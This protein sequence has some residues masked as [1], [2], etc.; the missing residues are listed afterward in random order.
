M[1]TPD[2]TEALITHARA[3]SLEAIPADAL[4]VA[5]QC[6]MDFT[7]CALGGANDPLV[8]ILV[9]ELAAP[10]AARAIARRHRARA[11]CTRTA[12]ADGQARNP[13]ITGYKFSTSP[14]R[15]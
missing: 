8:D 15:Y 10:Q 4:Q 6:L 13:M 9:A 5:R 1:S 7:A 11:Q 12:H 14:R 3:V 2:A